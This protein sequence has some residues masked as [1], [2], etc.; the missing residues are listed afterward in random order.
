MA[1][2]IMK[3]QTKQVEKSI[4]YAKNLGK[5][6]RLPDLPRFWKKHKKEGDHEVRKHS[7]SGT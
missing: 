6:G 7:C 3:A 1:C 5:P 4:C 2:F